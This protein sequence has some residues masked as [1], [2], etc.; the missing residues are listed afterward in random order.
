MILVIFFSLFYSKIW[1]Y[2]MHYGLSWL[3]TSDIGILKPQ[4]K[5]IH[6]YYINILFQYVVIKVVYYTHLLYEAYPKNTIVA[7]N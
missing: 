2:S 1:I 7:Y 5:L 3:F 6:G 4:V